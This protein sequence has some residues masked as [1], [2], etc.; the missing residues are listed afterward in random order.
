MVDFSIDR[1]IDRVEAVRKELQS[2]TPS[3]SQLEMLAN[4]I[5]YG[6]DQNGLNAVDRKEIQIDTKYNSYKKKKSESLD[7]LMETPTFNEN[8]ISPIK[9]SIYKN[10]KPKLDKN[11]KELQPLLES[12]EQYEKMKKKLE[13]CPEKTPQI[14]TKIWKLSH[15][16]IELRREQYF[17]QNLLKESIVQNSPSPK[18]PEEEP[19]F[20]VAPLGL[21]V[22][23]LERFENPKEDKSSFKLLDAGEQV[24]NFEDPFHI[25]NILDLWELLYESS[26]N[27]PYNNL[28]YLLETLDYY[29]EKANLDGVRLEI[30]KL[31]KLKYQ[32]GKIRKVLKSKYGIDY[33]ENYI[34]TI[35]TK[36]ICRKISEAATLHKEEWMARNDPGK[37]KKCICC[38][39]WQLRDP[40]NF[41][42]KKSAIDGFSSRCKKCDKLKRESKK[43]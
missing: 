1:D 15:T 16:I 17:L 30:L 9:R 41:V 28:K 31:K 3:P 40:R 43:K 6:H 38:G 4:Y 25:Y 24:L 8:E 5:L 11:L 2:K 22:G 29:I 18:T 32:N 36:E 7:E 39:R 37:W 26:L 13:Q 12:I 19:N 20:L 34:S 10:P 23:R 33:N 42:R 35:F 21:K 27:S 14:K